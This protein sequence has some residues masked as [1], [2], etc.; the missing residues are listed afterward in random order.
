MEILF[1]KLVMI[2]ELLRQNTSTLGTS[3]LDR[4][5][6]YFGTSGKYG[7]DSTGCI[8]I[9]M[10]TEVPKKFLTINKIST[11]LCFHAILTLISMNIIRKYKFSNIIY[12]E[13]TKKVV[14][15]YL[16]FHN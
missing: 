7:F 10:L 13:T 16:E 3:K 15:A 1:R 12:T 14:S 6:T 5:F 2:N 4:G 8:Q 9:D 11:E